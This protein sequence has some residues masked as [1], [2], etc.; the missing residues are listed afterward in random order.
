MLLKLKWI[1][2]AI[3]LLIGLN[4]GLFLIT[5]II[6]KLL[7]SILGGG[8]IGFVCMRGYLVEEAKNG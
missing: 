2:I 3:G 5:N 8:I 4:I 6:L 1:A 7:I